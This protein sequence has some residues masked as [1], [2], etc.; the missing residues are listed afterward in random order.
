MSHRFGRRVAAAALGM[1]LSVSSLGASA[2]ET[3]GLFGTWGPESTDPAAI[4]RESF[5]ARIEPRDAVLIDGPPVGD[6][7]RGQ[8]FNNAP[9]SGPMSLASSVPE[10]A[11]ALLLGL[12]LVGVVLQ[13]RRR[14]SAEDR[15]G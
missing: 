11:A 12:G 5:N 3:P 15:Q 13:A 7:L 6:A 4:D 10:P 9:R 2:S 14:R 1:A 8:L